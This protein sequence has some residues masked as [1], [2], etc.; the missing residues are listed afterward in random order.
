MGRTE[1][2]GGEKMKFEIRNR[3]TDSVMFEVEADSFVKAVEQKVKEGAN[4]RGANLR[5]AYLRGAY[6]RGA[7]LE[8]A[9]LRGANLR[10]AYLEG[11]YLEG[12]NLRGAY[13]RGAYLL[14]ANLEGAYLEGANLEG[15][16]LED[17]LLGNSVH[18]LLTAINWGS[19]PDDLTLELMRHD[20]ESCG[21]PKMDEWARGNVEE[22]NNTC[23]FSDS[24]RDYQFEEDP[25]IWHNATTEDKTPKY[26]GMELLRKLCE[27]KGIKTEKKEA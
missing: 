27:A 11:A 4:L 20:A 7:Y 12:A 15:A 16:Y 21:I 19:L 18:T 8:G 26:R 23:P 1:R 25:T 13:L 5:G 14:G 22:G 17:L 2:I 24:V 9:N 6:L 10:G 3:W